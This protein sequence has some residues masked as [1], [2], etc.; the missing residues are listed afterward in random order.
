M[1]IIVGVTCRLYR[2]TFLS[3]YVHKIL[4]A[5]QTEEVY[6]NHSLRLTSV[7]ALVKFRKFK[8]IQMIK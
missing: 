6:T 3:E 8:I 5:V 2:P 4:I 7:T 1:I